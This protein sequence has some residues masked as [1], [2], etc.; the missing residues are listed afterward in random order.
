MMS[1]IPTKGILVILYC[2]ISLCSV[3]INHMLLY[4]P[5]AVKSDIEKMC[6]EVTSEHYKYDVDL[7]RYFWWTCSVLNADPVPYRMIVRLFCALFLYWVYVAGTADDNR[8]QFPPEVW[9]AIQVNVMLMICSNVCHWSIKL[10]HWYLITH[11]CVGVVHL[12]INENSN[13]NVP[14]H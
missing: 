1:S 10:V 7:L 9:H 12:C 11:I 2:D 8:S 14:R 3:S 6:Y 4:G 5:Y 13:L